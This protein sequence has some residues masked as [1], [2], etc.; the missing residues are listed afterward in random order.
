[1]RVRKVRFDPDSKLGRIEPG[2]VVEEVDG[3]PVRDIID[4]RF[5]LGMGDAKVRFRKPDGGTAT[6]RLTE[7]E[8]SRIEFEPLKPRRCP[9]D[10]IFCFVHQMP[11]GL[12]KTLYVKDEDYRFSFLYGNYITLTN[13]SRADLE[14]IVTQRLSP[15]Y[16]SVHT[17]NLDLREEMLRSPRARRLL[18][19]M[20]YLCSHEITLH[21]QIVVCPGINDDK[22]LENTVLT[23]SQYTP[24]VASIA[25]VPVGLTTHRGGLPALRRMDAR[26]A[27]EIVE[28][29][30]NWQ[31]AFR[32]RRK[33]GLVYLSDEIF[34]VA[35][36][37]VPGSGYYDDF[38]QI[39]NGVGMVRQFLENIESGLAAFP[40]G[41]ED[42][43]LVTGE[44]FHPLLAAAARG[45]R[46]APPSLRVIEAR[47]RLFGRT[48]TVAGL[49]S[50]ADILGRI[51]SLRS[52]DVF[53]SA[54]CID[55]RG[56]FIDNLT[57]R[58]LSRITQ[59]RIHVGLHPAV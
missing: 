1:L 59:K 21:T 58:E 33:R 2:W 41:L 8:A 7:E 32:R 14:R 39:E 23:L 56:R 19:V 29:G 17:T 22:E 54:E 36:V 26:L 43:V 28:A 16:V 27:L 12:R 6:M 42:A 57:V 20:D 46:N 34:L 37:D 4:F 53:L 49:L 55:S 30:R 25:I 5:G 44:L 11:P 31:D 40:P 51:D 24:Y 3:S 35:G 45:M 50:G 38:P 47:N 15:L 48:V 10:C 13:L 52:R 9:N 18:E